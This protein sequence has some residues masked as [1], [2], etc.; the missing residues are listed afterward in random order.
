MNEKI[1][2]LDA[3]FAEIS[4]VHALL[5]KFLDENIYSFTKYLEWTKQMQA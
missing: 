1:M 3:L 5:W 4:E 2:G